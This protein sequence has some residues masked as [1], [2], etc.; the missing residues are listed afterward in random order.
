MTYVINIW[1][2]FSNLGVNEQVSQK[3]RR[4][5]KICN[6]SLTIALL[7][8]VLLLASNLL[9]SNP[10][11]YLPGMSIIFLI[12]ALLYLNYSHKFQITQ[13]TINI[14]LPLVLLTL[15]ILYGKEGGI[16][17]N[18]MIFIMTA[19]FFNQKAILKILF[20]IYNF[21]LYLYLQFY[22][23]NY[24]S[25]FADKT[26]EFSQEIGFLST[27][28]IIVFL[29]FFYENENEN[30]DKEN[31]KLL[32]SLEKNNADLMNANKELERFAYIASHDLKTPLRTIVGYTK[33]IEKDLDKDHNSDRLNRYFEEI[34]KGAIQMNDLIKSTLEYSYISNNTNNTDIELAYIDL[35]Q[36]VANITNAYINDASV[37]ITTDQFPTI[38]GEE[39]QF[40]SL[41]QNLIENGIK[42]NEQSEKKINLTYYDLTDSHLIKVEDNGIGID[43]KYH[44]QIFTMFKRLHTNQQYEGT[45]LGLAI[46]EKLVAKM[47]GKIWFESEVGVGT[48]FFVALNKLKIKKGSI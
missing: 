39:N 23:T 4:R 38:R 7:A 11:G 44:D 20:I 31:Q 36:V 48:T 43:E 16:E 30:Y 24:K 13:L 2:F 42:Y 34:K 1:N 14:L 22:W 6:Q 29:L 35:N 9:D 15:G 10:E 26:A 27:A 46:C 5:I 3:N 45:G 33:L 21:S 40:F 18:F 17:Y 25:I 19:L 32:G 41:F 37:V 8:Q 28:I 12:S 47:N